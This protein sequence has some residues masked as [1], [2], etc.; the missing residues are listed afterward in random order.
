MTKKRK[1]FLEAV[2]HEIEQLKKYATAA[3]ISELDL[4]RFDASSQHDCIYGQMAGNCE[5]NRAKELMDK[6]CIKVMDL[7][8]EG[9]SQVLGLD[10]DDKSFN[11]NGKY[12]GQTWH[13]LENSWSRRR[14]RYLSA[15]EAYICTRDAKVKNVILYMQGKVDK[16]EL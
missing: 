11:V 5:T 13:G 3:E 1:K 4:E 6:A 7:D 2:I 9:V 10:I 14:Y 12:K 8:D 15:L 16:L